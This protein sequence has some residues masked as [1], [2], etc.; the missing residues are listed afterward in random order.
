MGVVT[1]FGE[2]GIKRDAMVTEIQE[3]FR[4]GIE[5]RFD[6]LDFFIDV[7]MLSAKMMSSTFLECMDFSY[8]L[9]LKQM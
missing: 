5:L 1:E 6:K 7:S 9:E 8:Y 2:I 3:F 4:Q